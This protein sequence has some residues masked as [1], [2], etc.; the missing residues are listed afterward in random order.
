MLYLKKK[1]DKTIFRN[2]MIYL[3]NM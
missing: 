1:K 3:K 2:T